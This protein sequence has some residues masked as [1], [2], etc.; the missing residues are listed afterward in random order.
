[1]SIKR[2]ADSVRSLP[3]FHGDSETGIFASQLV[4][5][6][7]QE[8]FRHEHTAMKWMNGGLIPIRTDMNAGAK[9]Y[10]AQEL[11]TVG[12]AALISDGAGDLPFADIE[13][14]TTARRIQSVGVAIRYS[15]QDIRT[16]QMQGLFD[17][18]AEKAAAAR[19]GMDRTL[20]DLIRTG[21]G[22][23]SLEGI[24]N[25]KGIITDTAI[26]GTWAS[27][28]AAQIV[29]D[30]RA[31]INTVINESDGVE[32][33]DTVVMPV[34]SYTLISTLQNSTASDITV[35]QYLQRAFPMIQRWEWEP[36]MSSVSAAGGNAL[37]VYRNDASRVR[38]VMPLL[39]EP[40]SPEPDG[41]TFKVSFETRYGGVMVQR[42]R[43][44]L[45]LD[46]I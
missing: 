27:A 22:A 31:A 11:N 37:L 20:N 13:G 40:T 8:L 12:R 3:M 17:V 18:A 33:P 39:M 45:R 15:R 21:D 36:G 14:E 4:T 2:I 7:F 46:G 32:M 34:E 25:A 38:A 29:A 23:A 16:A 30:V 1:M 42:P 41:L 9:S 10:L 24:T 19:E 5:A 6:T 44:I 28:T 43:S 26:T 35:L